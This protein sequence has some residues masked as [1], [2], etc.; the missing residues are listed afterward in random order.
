MRSVF[1]Y[2][3]KT[4][5]KVIMNKKWILRVTTALLILASIWICH[6]VLSVKSPHGI[7]QARAFYHQPLDSLDVLCVGSSHVHCGINTGE[8]W[9]DYGIAAYDFSAAEQT[10]WETYHYLIEA[11]KYQHPK[12]VILDVFSVARFREDYHYH[13][14][15]ES[16]FGLKPSYNKYQMLKVSAEKEN[17]KNYMPAFLTYHSRY[18]D[19][20]KED[21]YNV[22]GGH[23]EK[24]TFKGYT[25][26]FIVADQSDPFGGWDELDDYGLTAKSELYLKKII[27]LVKSEGSELKIIVVPYNLDERDRIT[28][29]DIEKIC[30]EEDISFIN[31]N[32]FLDDI[33]I[34][35]ATDF[36]DHTHLN[37]WGSVKFSNFL[38][39]EI[40]K[41]YDIIDR[42][43][44]K[45]YSSWD[46]NAENI[47][48]TAEKR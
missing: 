12:V 31:Y 20:N 14:M 34:D 42:R 32:D 5:N 48:K 47:R 9:D 43:N 41:E 26:G 4:S 7:N 18:V 24:K 29:A 8:L 40:K 13:W 19:L 1:F 37:Y 45:K 35:K 21:L 28:Y 39:S 16:F 30:S 46:E 25:P 17:F 23:L 3:I 15:E 33:G 36:N 11:Y 27:N 6:N 44:D 38:G 2:T 10:L 22:F